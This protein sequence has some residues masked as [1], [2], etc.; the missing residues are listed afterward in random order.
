MNASTPTQPK[1]EKLFRLAEVESLIGLKKTSIYALAHA[2]ELVP[3]RLSARSV[4]WRESDLLAWQ[5]KRQP[6]QLGLKKVAK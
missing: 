5:S 4:A 2:G 3:V 6:V 1:P